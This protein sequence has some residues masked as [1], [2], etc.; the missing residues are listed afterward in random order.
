MQ[1]NSMFHN[2]INNLF[3]EENNLP[4]TLFVA[5]KVAGS[6]T[7]KQS[8]TVRNF[9]VLKGQLSSHKNKEFVYLACLGIKQKK[10]MKIFLFWLSFFPQNYTVHLYA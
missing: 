5:R 9:V 3:S 8:Y 6:A 4:S 7:Y 1:N 10:S 2:W